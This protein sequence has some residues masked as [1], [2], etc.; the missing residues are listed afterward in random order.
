[1]RRGIFDMKLR[2]GMFEL[3]LIVILVI[4]IHAKRLLSRDSINKSISPANT[5]SSVIA[6]KAKD[7]VIMVSNNGHY[8]IA[9]HPGDWKLIFAAKELNSPPAMV[10]IHVNQ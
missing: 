1:M 9:L 5:T 8:G 6:G 4:G 2:R 7:S 10:V 3:C